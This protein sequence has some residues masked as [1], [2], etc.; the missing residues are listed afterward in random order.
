MKDINGISLEDAMKAVE[1]VIGLAGAQDDDPIAIT[2][3]GTNGEVI[4]QA[5]MDGVMPGS[6]ELSKN[7][8]YTALMTK[9]ETAFW[10]DQEAES[11]RTGGPRLLENFTNDRFTF[12]PGGVPVKD[13]EGRIIGAVG[14]SGRK[15]RQEEKEAKLPQDHELAH[16]AIGT[17]KKFC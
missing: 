2:I 8:A 3:I 13:K 9:K 14:V 6:I 10:A 5:A 7:K 15:G 4:I 12:F 16:G 11:T 1:G 17:L